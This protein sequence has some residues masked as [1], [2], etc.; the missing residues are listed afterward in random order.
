[1]G[2]PLLEKNSC[3]P[4]MEAAGRESRSSREADVASQR[5]LGGAL[6]FLGVVWF[7][8]LYFEVINILLGVRP[9]LV[10]KTVDPVIFWLASGVRRK[11]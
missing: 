3:D 11:I 5:W 9:Q 10:N 1:M 2:R 4:P 8:I 7:C 6:L